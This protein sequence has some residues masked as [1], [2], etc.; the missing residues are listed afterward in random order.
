V[1]DTLS[2]H[3]IPVFFIDLVLLAAMA[4]GST[5][6]P[7]EMSTRGVSWEGGKGGR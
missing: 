4:L 5:Q 3:N 2:N 7:T 6:L 1:Y